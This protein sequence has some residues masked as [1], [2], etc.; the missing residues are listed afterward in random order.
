M[1]PKGGRPLRVPELRRPRGEAPGTIWTV[2]FGRRAFLDENLS[3]LTGDAG[4]NQTLG[5]SV[6][7]GVHNRLRT[8]YGGISISISHTASS[9]PAASFGAP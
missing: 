5:D 3:R 4:V 6:D 9:V 1:P 7:A 8:P 2:R